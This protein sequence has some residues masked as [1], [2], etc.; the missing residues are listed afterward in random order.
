MEMSAAPD[1]KGRRAR[2]DGS[3]FTDEERKLFSGKNANP[4]GMPAGRQGSGPVGG[5]TGN[6]TAP[7][8]S[9]VPSGPV[10]SPPGRA[11]GDP[12]GEH[13][14]QMPQIYD[15]G[16]PKD[17]L[18]SKTVRTGPAFGIDLH[19]RERFEP[20]EQALGSRM[21]MSRQSRLILFL[22]IVCILLF[23]AVMILPNYT[24]DVNNRNLSLAWFLSMVQQRINYIGLALSGQGAFGGIDYTF[25]RY[26]IVTMAGAALAVSGAAYQ[27]SLKNQLA[28]PST[29]GVMSGAQLGSVLLVL[30]APM[31]PALT[32]VASGDTLSEVSSSLFSEMS[33]LEYTLAIAQRPLFSL[34]GSL[35]VI[36]FV[37]GV[38]FVA[39]HG[40]SSRVAMII[41]GQII[42]GCVASFV[43][44]ARMYIQTYG[45]TE[46]VDAITATMGGGFDDLFT[47]LHVVLMGVPVLVCL[48]IV[49]ALRN[50]L[51]L[52]AFDEQE[53]R[54]MGI[55]TGRL[56]VT[57]V[58][59]CTVLTA[60]IVAFCGGV[61]FI[62]FLIP[63]L[64]RR[65]VGPDFK[66]LLPASALLGSS[67]LLIVYFVYSNITVPIG[68]ISMITTTLGVI[69]FIVV[70][71][72]QRQVGNAGW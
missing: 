9:S 20:Q 72:R 4:I 65:L 7:P 2:R 62:G 69:A 41:T 40:R 39:G 26:L 42:A 21:R 44:M 11:T 66:Y 5:V 3:L 56:R 19:R 27:G 46:Q 45:T 55:A 67:F 33:L 51:N 64:S 30:L 36:A 61:G 54:S 38:S 12:A 71:I 16:K 52:L 18:M 60:V 15:P 43:V 25:Y 50:K 49:F 47:L 24:F 31:V 63:H 14:Y 68:S 70:L 23:C 28:S 8:A 29:L 34:A 59:C 13:L 57:L 32:Y 1:E 10:A 17:D 48:I 37:L 22:G 6:R 58:A 53:A 35:I